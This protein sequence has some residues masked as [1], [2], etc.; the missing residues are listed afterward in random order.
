M[1]LHLTT[2]D[3]RLL[4]GILL[5]FAETFE[6]CEEEADRVAV[7]THSAEVHRT[8]RCMPLRR[9]SFAA[10]RSSIH[11]E[12]F[13]DIQQQYGLGDARTD[14]IGSRMHKGPSTMGDRTRSSKHSRS[15]PQGCT[16]SRQ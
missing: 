15:D 16:G 5:D 10:W 1:T 13:S 14:V 9:R 7:A 12:S 11:V 6:D 8:A 3:A 2:G 4:R